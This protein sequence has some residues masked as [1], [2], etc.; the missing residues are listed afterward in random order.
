MFS[1]EGKVV[2]EYRELLLLVLFSRKV[3]AYFDSQRSGLHVERRKYTDFRNE[4]LIH[5]LH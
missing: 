2:V 3:F 5:N 1:F 4:Y